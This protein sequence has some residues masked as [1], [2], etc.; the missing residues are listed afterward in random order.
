MLKV[1]GDNGLGF[2][3]QLRLCRVLGLG[4]LWFAGFLG[5][6]PKP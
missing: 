1:Y 2:R 4:F 3:V 6:R 5:G